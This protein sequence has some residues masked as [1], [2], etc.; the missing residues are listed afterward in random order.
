MVN[1]DL[2]ASAT[3]PRNACLDAIDSVDVFISIVGERAGHIAPSGK[4]VI[5]EEYEHARKRTLPVFAFLQATTRDAPTDAFTRELS[6]YVAGIIRR[7]FNS[8]DELRR[9]IID[10]LGLL[11][12]QIE[13][14]SMDSEIFAKE[15]ADVQRVVDE[16]FVRVIFA[17]ERQEEVVDPITLESAEFLSSLYSLGHSRSVGLFDYEKPK[18]PSVKRTSIVV[19]Q[20]E[21]NGGNRN[22]RDVVRLEVT[23]QGWTIFD[24]NITGKVFRGSLHSM[25]NYMVIAEEDLCC[26]LVSF[27]RFTLALYEKIDPH[28][29]HQ[30]FCYNSAVSNVGERKLVKQPREQ[31]SYAVNRFTEN[32]PI[33][34]FEAPQIVARHDLGQP[35][36]VVEKTLVRLRRAMN[37]NE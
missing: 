15:L 17:P 26:R 28:M 37:S 25:I 8:V 27:F 35:E 22:E 5:V 36:Q 10:S 20:S 12:R 29:R 11:K 30:R 6:D 7:E 31:E 24:A 2:P 18:K 19:L 9:A 14:P 4:P 23:E 34:I 32:K 21:Y 33:V 3:S 13:L 16:V 1:E